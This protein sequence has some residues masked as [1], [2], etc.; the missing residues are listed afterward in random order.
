MGGDGAV[1]SRFRSPARIVL[2][3]AAMVASVTIA[4]GADAATPAGSLHACADPHGRLA[5]QK[6]G[7]CA[8]GQRRIVVPLK[9]VPG[10]QGLPGPTGAFP[11]TLSSGTTLKGVWATGFTATASGQY[12][13]YAVPFTYAFATAPQP[14]LVVSGI[15]S[16]SSKYCPGSPSDPSAAPGYVCIYAETDTAG[17]SEPYSTLTSQIGNATRFG[18]GLAVGSNSAGVTYLGGSWAATAP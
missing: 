1:T 15:P 14:L 8:T 10:P 16:T 2:T 18:W 3:V 13:N 12:L 4:G 17:Y 6:R 7:H 5:V 9:T 11:S